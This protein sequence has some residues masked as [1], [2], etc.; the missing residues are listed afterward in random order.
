M[1]KYYIVNGAEFCGWDYQWHVCYLGKNNVEYIL[2][3]CNS[4]GS[5]QRICKVLNNP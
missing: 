3:D 4:K 2:C 5:A 1:K